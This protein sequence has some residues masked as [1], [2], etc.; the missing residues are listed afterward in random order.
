M[1]AIGWH[2]PIF[3]GASGSIGREAGSSFGLRIADCGEAGIE[4]GADIVRI[5]LV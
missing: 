1:M 4:G 2:E 5:E 3:W